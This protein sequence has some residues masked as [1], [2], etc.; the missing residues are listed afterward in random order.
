MIHKNSKIRNIIEMNKR[1]SRYIAS[2]LN[3]SGRI[4]REEIRKILLEKNTNSRF[5]VK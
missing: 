5:Y 2:E 4:K 1:N 3:K